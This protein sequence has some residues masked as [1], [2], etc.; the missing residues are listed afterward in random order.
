MP[1]ERSTRAIDFVPNVILSGTEVGNYGPHP[2]SVLSFEFHNG[3]GEDITV[4][5]RT[6]V[7]IQIPPLRNARFHNFVI[8]TKYAA[9]FNVIVDVGNTSY[10]QGHTSSL[11]AQ[12]IESVVFRT[13]FGNNGMRSN[14]AT[15]EYRISRQEFA[16]GGG[17]LYLP[18]LD[19]LVSSLS[20]NYVPLHPFSRAGLRQSMID[21]DP[22]LNSREGLSFNV[23]IIDKHG[24]YGDRFLN[25]DGKVY[26]VRACKDSVVP[27]GVYVVSHVPATGNLDVLLPR[28]EYYT[29]EEADKA[30]SLYLTYNEAKT[31]GNPQDVY[32][33]ELDERTHRLKIEQ[34]DWDRER[35]ERER[36]LTESRRL[37]E[38][39]KERAR[40]EQASRDEELRRRQHAL[41]ILEREN[42]LKK[43]QFERDTLF[44][45][46]NYEASSARRKEFIEVLKYVPAVIATVGGIYAAYKKLKS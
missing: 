42:S 4:V 33:R 43:A 26:R 25:I 5:T 8:V 18:N 17:S 14:T 34:Q 15:V 12:K 44:I 19:L 21:N 6:G 11:E 29:F 13:D 1:Q 22:L 35:F 7:Q 40:R 38:E 39:E 45:K 2:Q 31:L 36:E 37:L 30:L 28:S 16:E 24:R 3:T 9:G 10:D 32:K 41:D 20:S 46:Q 23:R 27:D